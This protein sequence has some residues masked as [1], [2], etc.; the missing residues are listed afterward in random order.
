MNTCGE[1]W[2]GI[3]QREKL[4]FVVVTT[5]ASHF[6]RGSLKLGWPLKVVLL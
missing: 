2:P 5:K 4:N 6:H 1:L 3:G